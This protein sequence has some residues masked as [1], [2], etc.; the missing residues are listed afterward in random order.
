MIQTR[1]AIVI[2]LACFLIISDRSRAD[3]VEILTG[4]GAIVAQPPATK[5]PAASPNLLRLSKVTVATFS[6][7]GKVLLTVSEEDKQV[8]LWNAETGEE[9]NRFGDSITSA[10]FSAGGNRV[11]TWGTDGVTRIFDTRTGKA[12][13]RLEGAG[14]S[15]RA[16]AIS[17]DGSRALTCAADENVPKLWDAATGQMIGKLETKTSPITGLAFSPDCKQAV[18]LSGEFPA[19]AFKPITVAKNS[20][21]HLWDLKPLKESKTIALPSAASA[22]YFSANGKLVLVI[23]GNAA[24]IY[25][26]ESGQEVAAPRTADERFP[27]G[28]LTGDRKTS[29]AKT[30]GLTSL[31]N[32]ADNAKIRPLEGAI[33]GMPVCNAFSTDGS[34]VI[35]G[36]GKVSLFSRNP[37]EP[38][39]VYVYEVASGKRLAAFDGHAREVTQVSLSAD[40]TRGFSRDGEKTVLLW[41]VPH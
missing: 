33:D 36:T 8:H 18:V 29:I 9:A 11:M 23:A 37:N 22:V 3:D 12:L 38:G 19:D 1:S 15:L 2:C 10:I 28:S 7:D 40:A 17:P 31:I 24:K 32:V 30:I 16:G 21:L 4:P 34:R 41:A 39:K 25:E 26:L 5:A 13:R 14:N 6:P 20:S 27:S 35:I